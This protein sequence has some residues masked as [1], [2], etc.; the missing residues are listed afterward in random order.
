[1]PV[2]RKR[3]G[4]CERPRPDDPRY[5]EPVRQV[6]GLFGAA[7]LLAT[8]ASAQELNLSRD[9]VRAG[10][11]SNL[12]PNRPDV[13]ARPAFQAAIDYVR[14]QGITRVTLDPGDYYFL[15]T[16]T[17][18]RYV[19]IANLS[20]VTFAF[21]GV[22]L[23][24]RDPYALFAIQVVNSE[25][26][27][28]SG[29]T[30]DFM[31][32]PFTQVRV[33][34]V[35]PS[36]RTIRYEPLPGH[37]PATDF[38]DLRQVNGEFP[39]LFGLAFRGTGVVPDT[40]RFAIARPVSENT[41][42]AADDGA[43]QN[44]PSALARI[45]PGDTLVLLGRNEQGLAVRV[46]GGSAIAFED[47]DVYASS[48]MAILFVQVGAARLERTRVLPRPGTDRLISTNADGLNFTLVQAGSLMR[49]CVVRG[50]M[51]DGIAVN[52]MF[53]A[54][55]LESTAPNRLTVRRRASTKFENGLSLALVASTS[56]AELPGGRILSQDPA[57][58]SPVIS[59]GEVRL[60][61][62]RGLAAVTRD[63][64]LVLADAAARGEGTVVE[65]NLVED[66]QF[67][68]GIYIAGVMGVIVRGNVVRRTTSG[69]IVVWQAM[70]VPGFAV[71]P[72]HNVQI[73]Q[74]VVEQPISVG[75]IGTGSFAA[76]GGISVASAVSGRFATAY[77][78]SDVTI[79]GNRI[80]DSGRSG[81][82]VTSTAGGSIRDNVIE[83]HHRRPG[84]PLVGVAQAEH[85]QLHEDFSRPVVVRHSD[86]VHVS[87]N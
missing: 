5:S 4:A 66:V 60:E 40:G 10:V 26:L 2:S 71:P 20:D 18:G 17:N 78:N 3:Q 85:T 52:S 22:N 33:A 70:N 54:S 46:D 12:E 59:N 39:D 21:P 45:L 80:S 82:F 25:R 50:T 36:E 30:V 74:N 31:A 62:D 73:L 48:A 16:Q 56:A 57:F 34:E 51:D 83:R 67:A 27:T 65:N 75:T 68:R 35:R 11:A 77:V 43:Y 14:R 61:F 13:D 38:N 79:A 49:D 63:S 19:Y 64:G 44:E 15:T 9:L 81:I 29:F 1:M 23:Y 69:G 86:G 28:F 58:E 41:L 37:R 55:V 8:S 84:L 72:V 6:A 87:G 47:V 42:R 24:F 7:I 32:L 53:V 76:L